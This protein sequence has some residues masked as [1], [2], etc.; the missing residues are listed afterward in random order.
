MLI[1]PCPMLFTFYLC[2]GVKMF[3]QNLKVWCVSGSAYEI[4]NEMQGMERG[5]DCFF[6]FLAIVVRTVVVNCLIYR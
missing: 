6:L 4:I 1:C 2:I 5:R 3:T